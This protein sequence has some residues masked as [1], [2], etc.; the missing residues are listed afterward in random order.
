MGLWLIGSDTLARSRFTVSPLAET[1]GR[2]LILVGRPTPAGER[3]W[4]DTHRR[5]YRDRIAADPFA[6]L[7]VRVAFRRSWLPGFLTVPPRPGDRGVDDELDRVRA[8]PVDAYLD[9]LAVTLQGP[10]PE[11]LRVPDGAARVA[12]LL[13]WVWRHGVAPDW[14]WR[15]RAFEADV[16][17]RTQQ[18][19]AGGWATALDAMRPGM[20]WLGDGRLQINTYDY[21]PHDISGGELVFI[22]ATAHRGWVAS[23]PP[24]RRY[25][26]VYPCSGLL[27]RPRTGLAPESLARLL[28]PVRAGILTALDT[29][30]ST[31]QLVGLTGHGLGS[32]GGHLR[33]LLDA[34]L[35]GR[36]R[37][38]RSV[39]YYRTAAG[40]DLVRVQSQPGV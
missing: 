12:D 31:T 34:R 24:Q 20:R 25:A 17:A 15:V 16:V 11:G 36:R 6:A 13:S 27:A 26:V 9:D 5:A 4:L 19:S 32:V 28:G 18:L 7:F 37:S 2:L 30:K 22:P 23:D 10:V 40:D 33:V 3:G 39:L 35:V 8:T 29:P 14:S 21:P 1:V 38:G